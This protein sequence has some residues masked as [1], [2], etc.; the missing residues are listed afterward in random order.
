MVALSH[1]VV[2]KVFSTVL[3]VLLYYYL[4]PKRSFLSKSLASSRWLSHGALASTAARTSQ[5][6]PL[7]LLLALAKEVLV[8]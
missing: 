8:R 4:C 2:R 7:D 1:S 5:K 6:S 3:A